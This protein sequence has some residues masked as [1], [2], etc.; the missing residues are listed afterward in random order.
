MEWLEISKTAAQ[1]GLIPILIAAIIIL[2]RKWWD[3]VDTLV[4]KYE[5]VIVTK[6]AVIADLTDKNEKLGEKR[7][8]EYRLMVNDY[9]DAL[10]TTNGRDA[11]LASGQKVGNALL[12]QLVAQRPGGLG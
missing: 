1:L 3:M 10:E 4:T 8:E 6:D 12:Q 11:E 7:L 2:W 5:G 9:R